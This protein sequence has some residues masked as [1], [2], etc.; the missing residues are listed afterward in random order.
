MLTKVSKRLQKKYVLHFFLGGAN[1]DIIFCSRKLGNEWT[2]WF[3]HWFWKVSFSWRSMCAV[4]W[5][6]PA[7]GD[8]FLTRSCF[9][10]GSSLFHSVRRPNLS[11][12]LHGFPS[13]SLHTE[14]LGGTIGSP[15]IWQNHPG[16]NQR[17]PLSLRLPETNIKHS[18]KYAFS[19]RIVSQP[20]IF[21][22]YMSLT[23]GFFF[24]P[25]KN[26]LLQQS[27]LRQRHVHLQPSIVERLLLFCFKE[28]LEDHPIECKWWSDH[29]HL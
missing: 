17:I 26:D 7:F 15:R 2:W 11:N 22:G 18:W 28:C 27:C 23:E 5:F 9:V 10:F 8:V 6:Y 3:L 29:P 25:P 4:C 21:M 24:G 13:G 19:D 20:S 12:Y 14:H 1:D 16:S